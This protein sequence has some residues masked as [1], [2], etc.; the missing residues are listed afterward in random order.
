MKINLGTESITQETCNSTVQ[1]ERTIDKIIQT[2]DL[3]KSKNSLILLK[4]N[5]NNDL[6][7]LT[8]NS[9][10]LRI[11]VAV[12]KALKKR[13]YNNIVIADSPNCGVSAYGL[14]VIKRL[15]IN[16]IAELF[17]IKCLDLDNAEYEFVK[18]NDKTIKVPKIC[19]NSY[20]INLPKIK[21]HIQ[22]GLSICS[23]NLVGC[24]PGIE[25]RKIHTNLHKNIVEIN[26]I[27]KPDL[28]II[29][30]LYTM[31]G[32]GPADGIP[33]K[34]NLIISGKNPFLLDAYCAKLLN[35]KL[36]EIKYLQHAYKNNYL[37]NENIT[38]LNNIKPII[39]FKKS[40]QNLLSKILLRNFFIIPR[41]KYFNKIFNKGII[42]N[43]LIKLRVR[44]DVYTDEEP[45]AKLTGTFTNL[46][47]I[48]PLKL[49][50]PEDKKCIQCFYCYF[51]NPNE[52][53]TQGSL[54]FLEFQFKKFG[55]YIIN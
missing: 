54:G 29:D 45:N 52:I 34:L 32:N 4:P 6:I 43:T 24:F 48:C 44:Q 46:E 25:K 49:K 7:A 39:N 37:T 3:P 10:D 53:K 8:G 9:T 19:L 30:G 5:L 22:A 31:A 38:H 35:F 26:E 11:I 1:I 23:K 16:K 51:K 18:L 2:Q 14:D 36:N 28:H 13:K 41:Y 47:S 50:T 27:I 21:S 40:N 15:K 20:I 17:K 12:I 42:P 33:T 55:K